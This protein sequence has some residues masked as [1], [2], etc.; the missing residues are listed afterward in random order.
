MEP[1]FVGVHPSVFRIALK[2]L[3]D[4]PPLH[5]MLIVFGVSVV[6]VLSLVYIWVLV[7]GRRT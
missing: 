7:R 5:L 6:I 1:Y 4:L 3:F 2:T